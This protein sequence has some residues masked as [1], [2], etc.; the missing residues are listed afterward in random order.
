MR[1]GVGGFS[2]GLVGGVTNVLGWWADSPLLKFLGLFITM[3]GVGVG[4]LA[5][6]G[7]FLIGIGQ[8]KHVKKVFVLLGLDVMNNKT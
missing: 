3:S 1:I 7:L 5:T 6:M 2:A 8:E 4:I